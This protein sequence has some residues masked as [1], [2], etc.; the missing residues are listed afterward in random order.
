[1]DANEKYLIASLLKL[2][3]SQRLLKNKEEKLKQE[4]AINQRLKE[5]QKIIQDNLNQLANAN[6]P[7]SNV[8]T[9]QAIQQK[10]YTIPFKATGTSVQLKMLRD[11]MEREGI[12]YESITDSQAKI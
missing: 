11:F 10:V 1:M 4:E 7:T 2:V 9:A 6:I 3:I 12:E 5:G 8:N